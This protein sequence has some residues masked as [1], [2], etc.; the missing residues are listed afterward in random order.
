M[1][2]RDHGF[3]PKRMEVLDSSRLKDF[4]DCPS[5]FYLRHILG[6]KPA[7]LDTQSESK[8]SWGTCWHKVLEVYFAEG[9]DK[10]AALKAL[11]EEYPSYITADQDKFKRTKDRMIEAFFK[12]LDKWEENLNNLE[13]LRNEQFFDQYSEDDGLRWCGRI[14]SIRRRKTTGAIVVWDYKTSSA[15][16][17]LYFDQHEIGFQFPGYV[18]A[19][20]QM[21]GGEVNEITVDVLYMI[22][23]SMDL[24]QK[25]FRYDSS[26]IK[27]WVTNVKMWIDQIYRLQDA[28]LYN[29]NL[30][31]K[32]WNECTRYG[33]CTYFDVHSITPRGSARL[34]ILTSGYKEERWEPSEV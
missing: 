13:V 14:D 24:R 26:R 25:T 5:K 15:M 19:A 20:N 23:R 31:A 34:N 3:N 4:V 33:R 28:H 32:N 16:G 18:W 9:R 27:E 8:F 29:P 17:P 2:I 22:T 6:L 21:M 7:V 10:V 1:D 11:D 12:Y 30:W